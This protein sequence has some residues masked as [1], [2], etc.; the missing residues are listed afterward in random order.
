MG[1]RWR[2]CEE[3]DPLVAARK[4]NELGRGGGSGATC[5][6]LMCRVKMPLERPWVA[7]SCWIIHAHTFLSLLL[8]IYIY[9]PVTN[10][11]SFPPPCTS[12]VNKQT[13]TYTHACTHAC[14]DYILFM[15]HS[16]TTYGQ[17][18]YTIIAKSLEVWVS[19]SLVLR[20]TCSPDLACSL[21]H[22]IVIH[23]K[24]FQD[25]I[26]TRA[27][28]TRDSWMWRVHSIESWY[29]WVWSVHPMAI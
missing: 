26:V 19:T 5:V 15:V 24:D 23:F 27:T 20:E 18:I 28:E 10:I 7:I 4:M 16:P 21:W 13:Q 6:Q 8:D 17:C 14:Y 9:N 25:D 12:I 1:R 11:Q 3:G 2:G 29:I 22:L